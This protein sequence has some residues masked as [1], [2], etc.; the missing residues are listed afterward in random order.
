MFF[1]NFIGGRRLSGRYITPRA[2]TPIPDLKNQKPKRI[3]YEAGG[4]II[5]HVEISYRICTICIS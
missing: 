1:L 4:E 3:P 2:Q 5:S